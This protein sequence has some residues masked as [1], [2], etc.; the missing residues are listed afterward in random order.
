[1]VATIHGKVFQL[2]NLHQHW[3]KTMC[4]LIVY[5]PGENAEFILFHVSMRRF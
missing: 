2:L 4:F 1:M 5:H 3:L